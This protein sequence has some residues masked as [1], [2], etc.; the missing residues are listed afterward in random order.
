MPWYAA[1][2]LEHAGIEGCRRRASTV[3]PRDYLDLAHHVEAGGC[4]PVA[5]FRLRGAG[6]QQRSDRRHQRPAGF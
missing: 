6:E 3:L 2:G 1:H 5:S 4:L